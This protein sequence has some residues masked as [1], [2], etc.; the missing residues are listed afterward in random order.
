[1][2]NIEYILEQYKNRLVDISTRNRTLCLTKLY[3]RRSFDL[4]LLEE[5][6]NGIIEKVLEH[7]INRNGKKVCILDIENINI[8]NE[9][10]EDL[11]KNELSN[12]SHI[13]RT[14]KRE[15]DL[16]E[17]ETGRYELFVAYPFIE[18]K[19]LDGTYVK[20][21]IF[22]FPVKLDYSNGKWYLERIKDEEVLLN[23]VFLIA[24]KRYNSAKIIEEDYK[25]DFSLESI[26]EYFRNIGIKLAWNNSTKIE[27]F[28]EGKENKIPSGILE[29]KN[30]IIL[31]NF[32]IA[33]SIYSDYI[34]LENKVINNELLKLLLTGKKKEN[35]SKYENLKDNEQ[36]DEKNF[37]YISSLDFSQEKAIK[38]ANEKDGVVIYGP[39]GTGKSQTISNLIADFLAKGKRVLVVS[40]KRAA[41]D[42]LLNRLSPIKSKVMLVHDSQK[43]KKEIY[44]KI[45]QEY[46]KVIN[47]SIEGKLKKI[48]NYSKKIEEKLIELEEF[49]DTMYKEREF[50]LSL[51]N[52]Y[53]LTSKNL[54]NKERE[55][56]LDFRSNFSG[57]YK[58]DDIKES[59]NRVKGL[60]KNYIRYRNIEEEYKKQIKDTKKGLDSFLIQHTLD[61]FSKLQFEWKI[62]FNSKY[63]EEIKRALQEKEEINTLVKE[64]NESINLELFKKLKKVSEFKWYNP[65]HIIFL[66]FRRK[67][68]E[69]LERLIEEKESEIL[70]EIKNDF[71]KGKEILS[72][73]GFLENVID[74]FSMFEKKILDEQDLKE[75]IGKLKDFLKVYEEYYTLDSQLLEILE[76]DRKI[77]E[78]IYQQ[79]N[80]GIDFVFHR[81]EK[82]FILNEIT[83]IEKEEKPKIVKYKSY[84]NIVKEVFENM[85]NKKIT[86]KEHIIN[87]WNKEFLN[88]LRGDEKLSKNF[89]RQINKKSKLWSIRKLIENFNL[90][91]L[92]LFPC[93]LATPET[94]SEIFPLK[95]GLFD[96]IIFDEASQIFI[97]KSIPAIYRAKK[98]VVSGDDKQLKPTSVFMIREEQDEEFDMEISAAMEEESL[99][100]VAK[101]NF[102]STHLLFHYRSEYKE[103]IEFS[104]H[105]FYDGRLYVSPNI[106]NEKP[107]ERIKVNGTWKNRQNLEEAKE[108]VKLVK[109]ILKERE[110]KETIGIVTFNLNQRN[111]IYDLLDNESMNDPEFQSL[112]EIESNRVENGEDKSIFVKNIENVQGDERDIIIFSTSYAKDQ[113]GKFRFNFGLL[114][115]E[116]GENRL[117]VAISRAKKKIYVVTSFEPEELEV[118]SSK[119]RGPKLLKEYLKYVRAIS[120]GNIEEANNILY[121][122]SNVKNNKSSEPE[123]F[124]SPFEEEVYEYLEN[125]QIL[126]KYDLELHTQVVSS[127]YRIDLGVYDKKFG[128]Y[129]LGIECDGARYH[130]SLTARERDIH[131]Q[132]FLESKGWKIVRIWSKDWWQDKESQVKKVELFIE[133]ELEKYLDASV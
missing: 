80:Y 44:N 35:F 84:N 43:E 128:R 75:Y 54:E 17:K 48:N 2:S 49:S 99:L 4:F 106:S 58:Y 104:N 124:E 102:D 132:R 112:Y 83:K 24:F 21:P 85:E 62:N 115:Q 103:L 88:T 1:M 64:I 41:L 66:K 71:E 111:L 76:F 18:G 14:I 29:L 38:M 10:E 52:M 122:L 61:E 70:N 86:V 101:V 98:V 89:E 127:G 51:A 22:L 27:K 117:N 69:K 74:N 133:K 94:V 34:N 93:F 11:I 45:R 3:K 32:K 92:K 57:Q 46:I 20:S 95:E 7:I 109:K 105:A 31:G 78:F 30:Y 47:E 77:L 72:K 39:P 63:K 131:R 59:C 96:I 36:I 9:D 113:T 28:K 73:I 19:F 25:E 123:K 97:E 87:Y 15:I 37:F 16:I 82:F 108:V 12:F 8:I 56:F 129:V 60:L 116:G 119:N 33:S 114:S 6:F 26:I 100:D 55:L 68:K 13:L 107:I 91:V 125:S 118:E 40:E 42:V 126:K 110:N 5:Y 90:L 67:T 53:A 120:N 130:S 121:N 23:K 50:G 81:I 79:R 65:I